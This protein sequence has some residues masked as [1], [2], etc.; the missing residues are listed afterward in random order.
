MKPEAPQKRKS[1]WRWTIGLWVGGL[2]I[3]G[4]LSY[5]TRIL[6]QWLLGI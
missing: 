5:A 1:Q 3:A 2:L 4:S 6:M